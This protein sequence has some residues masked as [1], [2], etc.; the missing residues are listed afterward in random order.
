MRENH[1][2]LTQSSTVNEE[3]GVLSED[4][5][6]LLYYQTQ[7]SGNIKVL[8]LETGDIKSITS[9]DRNR[10]GAR[11]SPD[12]RF[13]AYMPGRYG[14][15]I[16]DRFGEQSIKNFASDERICQMLWSPDGKWIAYISMIRNNWWQR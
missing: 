11:L 15:E 14:A 7:R 10:R 6:K 1:L 5:K 16:I 8:N 2:Q 9:D 12:N 3:Y 4:G 13:V